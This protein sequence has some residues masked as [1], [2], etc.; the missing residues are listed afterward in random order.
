MNKL[1]K[2]QTFNT[3]SKDQIIPN[4]TTNYI[5]GIALLIFHWLKTRST[6]ILRLTLIHSKWLNIRPA[7]FTR[8]EISRAIDHLA[9]F[10]LIEV[11][12]DAK[13]SDI[14]LVLISQ[15]KK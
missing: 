15:Q 10:G 14:L 8:S 9:K 5:T 12:V 1:Y 3:T 11:Q 13:S 7:K 2:T 6:G 4:I